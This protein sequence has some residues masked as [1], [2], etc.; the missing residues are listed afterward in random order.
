MSPH[1][2]QSNDTLQQCIQNCLDTSRICIET[3]THAHEVGGQQAEPA[4]IKLLMDCSEIAQL[5]A[6][7][8]LRD[9]SFHKQ[10]CAVCADVCERCADACAT[11]GDDAW[12]NA[13][14]E[15]CRR[16]AES[17]RHMAGAAA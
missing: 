17:C 4:Y 16:S 9:S 12:I 15:T 2:H 13:C 7:F 10:T 6:H 5:S 14:M 11:R 1:A 8:M 3:L